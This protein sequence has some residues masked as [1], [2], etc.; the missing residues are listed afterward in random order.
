MARE[1]LSPKLLLILASVNQID[2]LILCHLILDKF[3]QIQNNVT[4]HFTLSNSFRETE[5]TEIHSYIG[6]RL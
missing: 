1:S 5:V 2:R 6:T 4:T 3:S